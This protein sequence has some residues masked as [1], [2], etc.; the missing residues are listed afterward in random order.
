MEEERKERERRVDLGAEGE[1]VNK[2][3]AGTN[4]VREKDGR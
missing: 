1:G 3:E 4:C 2:K